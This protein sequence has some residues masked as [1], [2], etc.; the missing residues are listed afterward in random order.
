MALKQQKPLM[1]TVFALGESQL[2][3]NLTQI[4]NTFFFDTDPSCGIWAV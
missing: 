2:Q 3:Q 1:S 4:V